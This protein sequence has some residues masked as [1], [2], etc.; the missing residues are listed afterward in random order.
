MCLVLLSAGAT[1]ACGSDV[2]LEPT[3]GAG[4]SGGAVSSSSSTGAGAGGG[5]GLPCGPTADR[6]DLS[7]QTWDGL[8]LGCGSGLAE[9]VGTFVYDG[10]LQQ[11]QDGELT[12]DSCSPLADCLPM[13]ST[14][15]ISAPGLSPYLRS[16][17]YVRVTM[18]VAQPMGC[19]QAFTIVNLPEW[20]GVPNPVTPERRLW[21]AGAD[22]T[23][24]TLQ[25]SPFGIEKLPL[26][27]SEGTPG[28]DYALRFFPASDPAGG[29]TVGMGQT[30]YL[31]VGTNDAWILR[32][33]RSYESG[34]PDDFWNWAYWIAQPYPPD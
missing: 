27:C 16:G 20:D 14:L 32:N 30:A 28:D 18:Y 33:L 9:P 4:G 1:A 5:G 10:T 8:T 22:G 7:M 2:S 34:V 31:E 13:V 17:S 3:G 12:V 24:Q 29:V 19:E 6:L 15:R 26:G 25:D 23:A 21:L 11:T